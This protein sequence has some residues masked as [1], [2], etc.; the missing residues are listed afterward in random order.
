M[1]HEE[2]WK[3]VRVHP[4]PEIQ[5]L[6]P[7][8]PLP[9][10]VSRHHAHESETAQERDHSELANYRARDWTHQRAHGSAARGYLEADVGSELRARNCRSWRPEIWS[11]SVWFANTDR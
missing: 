6:R 7:H 5:R 2:F 4:R 9:P 10:G 3:T 8:D 1:H 11:I